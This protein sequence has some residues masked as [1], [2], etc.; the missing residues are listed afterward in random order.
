[1]NENTYQSASKEFTIGTV[2]ERT[3]RGWLIPVTFAMAGIIVMLVALPFS[4]P[5][6]TVSMI[7]VPPPSDQQQSNASGALSGLLS[8]A[9]GTAA[10][11][12]NN[13]LRYQKL[14]V[15]VAVAERMQEKHGMLQYAF[16]S[17]WDAKDKRW[18]Q[19]WSLRT[20]LLGWIFRLAHVPVWT[21]PDATTLAAFL[22]ANIVVV[23]STVN[24]LVIIS[25]TNPDPAFAKRILLTAHTEA[26]LVL[27]D[28]VARHASQQVNYLQNKLAGVS[29]ADY[30]A[31]LLQILS[32][33]EKTL[34]MTQTDAPFAADIASPPVASNVPTSPR[35]LL[36]I[37]LAALIGAL[38]GETL[39]VFL[40]P[41]RIRRAINVLRRK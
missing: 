35:P 21:P 2:I 10:Q 19:P 9:G 36:Y 4:V 5:R 23:P 15:S 11:S 17:Q 37:A 39:L 40:G 3:R 29:V 32:A 38:T 26:N 31:T 13:Y 18:V 27:R 25:M 28:M 6:Y 8:I 30:R 34:M 16:S 22:E 7:V 24:D 33:Q 1:M 14:L 41:D 20:M 12:G